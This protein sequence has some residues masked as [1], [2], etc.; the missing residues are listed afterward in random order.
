MR[1][2]Q[3]EKKLEI[4]TQNSACSI[5]GT[6]GNHSTIYVDGKK[7]DSEELSNTKIIKTSDKVIKIK[8]SNGSPSITTAS[9]FTT[10][11][12]DAS[13]KMHIES[14]VPQA[15]LPSFSK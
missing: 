2:R 13:S 9:K 14:I 4:N 15:K 8:S 11:T 1:T 3:I 12:F 5:S 7:I 10:I 6:L